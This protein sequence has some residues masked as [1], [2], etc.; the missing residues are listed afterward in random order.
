M[1]LRAHK[2]SF[3][4]KASAWLRTPVTPV[5]TADRAKPTP[6]FA[7]HGIGLSTTP[8]PCESAGSTGGHCPNPIRPT[9]RQ[10]DINHSWPLCLRMY[11][12]RKERFLRLADDAQAA[13]VDAARDTAPV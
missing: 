1:G 8:G 9:G 7:I 10:P 6:F 3:S 13:L 12:S 5:G 11:E 4:S 2:A